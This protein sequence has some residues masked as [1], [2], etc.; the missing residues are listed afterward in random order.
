MPLY[1]ITEAVDITDPNLSYYGCPCV[2]EDGVIYADVPDYAVES[3]IEVGRV[4]DV[5]CGKDEG[6]DK[7]AK[8]AKAQADKVAE[9]AAKALKEDP[10]SAEDVVDGKTEEAQEKKRKRRNKAE[11]AADKAAEVEAAKAKLADD[12]DMFGE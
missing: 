8:E 10:K 11:M 4:F 5:Q 7:A 1:K 6:S 12:A 2:V 3:Y 9:D